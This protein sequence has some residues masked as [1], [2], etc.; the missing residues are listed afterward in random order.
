MEGIRMEGYTNPYV[1]P[2]TFTR[3][4]AHLYFGRE[5]EARDLRDRVISERLVL[6]Y[7]QSG[8]GKSSLINTRLIPQL[9]AENFTVLPIGRIS[10]ALPTNINWVDNI[11]SFNLMLSLD[12]T[13]GDPNRFSDMNLSHFLAHLASD[14]GKYWYYDK[15]G[16]TG[17]AEGTHYLSTP[18]VLI[19]D[20]FEEL[21]TH[22]LE[23]WSE[24]G[25][26]FQ[27]LNQAMLNDPYLWVVLTL[28]EDYVAALEPYAPLIENRLRARFYMQRMRVEAALEAI[29]KPAAAFG[30][31]FASNVAEKLVDNLRRV[32]IIGKPSRMADTIEGTEYAGALGEFIEP[33]QLQAVCYQ[34]W[35]NLQQSQLSLITEQDLQEAGNIDRALTVFYERTISTVLAKMGHK[36]PERKLRNWFSRQLITEAET[37]GLI[38]QG[39][40]QTGDIPNELV[41]ELEHCF[42]LRSEIRGGG[43]WIELVH[44]RFIS[45]ILISNRKW[46]EN[47]EGLWLT[48]NSATNLDSLSES[49]RKIALIMTGLRPFQALE[50]DPASERTVLITEWLIPYEE[51]DRLLNIID[52]RKPNDKITIRRFDE[53]YK[54]ALIT[55]LPNTDDAEPDYSERARQKITTIYKNLRPFQA[56]EFDPQT[57]IIILITEWLIPF[58]NVGWLYDILAHR[59]DDEKVTIRRYDENYKVALIKRVSV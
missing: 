42:L 45:P 43:T 37:R 11:F 30:R 16:L 24:R 5:R 59:K 34:L 21:M 52:H 28:R 44:D 54:I 49:S 29:Q 56:L 31:P 25:K 38:Y 23:R 3:E 6:F 47:E 20:Q 35:E 27:Q 1:G 13:Q 32:Q 8:A 4:E 57:N 15:N 17:Y 46:I 41:K 40:N 26:F 2:R 18:S 51:G 58:D 50:Y 39:N 22:H 10:G 9:Q 14:D 53:N 7:A 48:D 36:V 12:Q 19:I 33:V 55:R